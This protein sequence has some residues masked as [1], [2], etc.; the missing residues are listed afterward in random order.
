VSGLCSI[1]NGGQEER[2]VFGVVKVGVFLRF[3]LALSGCE[4]KKKRRYL[5]VVS[6]GGCGGGQDLKMAVWASGKA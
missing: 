5:L 2:E 4:Q 3:T 1:T 6:G